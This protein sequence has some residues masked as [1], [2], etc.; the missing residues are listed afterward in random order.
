MLSSPYLVSFSMSV[1]CKGDR[2]LQQY[3]RCLIFTIHLSSYYLTSSESWSSTSKCKKN[4]RHIS[5]R[6]THLSVGIFGIEVVMGVLYLTYAFFLFICFNLDNRQDFIRL[7]NLS[8]ICSICI[9]SQSSA[10]S[11]ILFR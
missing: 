10:P 5:R 2:Y 3:S 6:R 1:R 4:V 8:Y 11:V 9:D 7:A